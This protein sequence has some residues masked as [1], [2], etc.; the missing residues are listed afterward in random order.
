MNPSIKIVPCSYPIDDLS[1][2]LRA[3]TENGMEPIAAVWGTSVASAETAGEIVTRAVNSHEQMLAALKMFMAQ[4]DGPGS[5][6]ANRPE[7]I[8][9]RAAIAQAERVTNS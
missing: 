7:I 2:E 1:V 3:F 6:R 8:A 4:Y 5:D 9:G